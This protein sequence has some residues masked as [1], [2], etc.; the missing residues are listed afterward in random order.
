M[1]IYFVQMLAAMFKVSPE[2]LVWARETID[3]GRTLLIA[4][5]YTEEGAKK[6][7]F[8]QRR[9]TVIVHPDGL[10]KVIISN[11]VEVIPEDVIEW[12]SNHMG[13]PMPVKESSNTQSEA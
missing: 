11:D 13:F 3:N 2:D 1:F 9:K 6:A 4:W 5:G 12:V 7:L 8:S 10:L